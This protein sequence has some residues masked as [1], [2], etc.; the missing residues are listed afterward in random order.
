MQISEGLLLYFGGIESSL[1]EPCLNK[2]NINLNMRAQY[3][4]KPVATINV[5]FLAI[6][7]W[8]DGF[9]RVF[10]GII[11]PMPLRLITYM[12]CNNFSLQKLSSVCET[13]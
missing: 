8:F 4:V 10:S 12:Q 11:E 1:S 6:L 5:S 7:S 9:E 3:G 2:S 13:L